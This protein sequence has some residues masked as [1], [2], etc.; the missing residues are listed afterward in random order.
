MTRLRARSG[1]TATEYVGM[2]F[3]V[4]VMIAAIAGSG[5]DG[6][7]TRSIRGRLQ[8]VR[9]GRMDGRPDGPIEAVAVGPARAASP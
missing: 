3:V 6:E 9:R 7:I 2:L 8:R 4:A 1:Q 5:V